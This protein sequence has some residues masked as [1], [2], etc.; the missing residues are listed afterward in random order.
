MKVLILGMSWF[1]STAKNCTGV[2]F[3]EMSLQQSSQATDSYKN[4]TC[5]LKF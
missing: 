4:V 5:E 1:K 2:I 3:S